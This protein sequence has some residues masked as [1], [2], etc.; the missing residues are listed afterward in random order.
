MTDY[1]P[2]DP[3]EYN[4]DEVILSTQRNDHSVDIT[5]TIA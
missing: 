1:I 2:F 3:H 5:P 4:L